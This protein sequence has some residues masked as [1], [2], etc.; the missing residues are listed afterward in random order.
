MTKDSVRNDE[1]IA[2]D[3]VG[4]LLREA[5]VKAGFSVIQISE[6]TRITKAHITAL[7]ANDFESLP[8]IAYIPG[9]I[10]ELLQSCW[11]K[12]NAAYQSL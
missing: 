11:V 3:E 8:G 1:A 2:A 5:R 7:E 9:F 4:S 6:L 10:R 12:S